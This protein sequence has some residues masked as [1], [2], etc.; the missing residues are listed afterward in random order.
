MTFH[1]LVAQQNQFLITK[2]SIIYLI[3]LKTM[4]HSSFVFLQFPQI[5][6][7]LFPLVSKITVH[8][9]I[10]LNHYNLHLIRLL[11]MVMQI[12]QQVKFLILINY[13]LQMN[14]N[15]TVHDLLTRIK[16][17]LF[18]SDCLFLVMIKTKSF[19]CF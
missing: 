15:Q 2:E 16:L 19:W 6:I 3:L 7:S 12:S 13:Q 9:F 10:I 18:F 8:Q 11:S 1:L 5:K 14:S 17:L 4:L